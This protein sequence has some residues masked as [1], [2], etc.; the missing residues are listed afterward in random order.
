MNKKFLISGLI[1]TLINL[2]L[3]AAAYI[4]ILKDFYQSHPAVSEEFMKQLHKQPDQLIVWAMVVTSLAMGF[5][6][7][8]VIKWSGA[9]T[10]VSGLK[11]GFV[12]ALLFWGSVNFG[13]YAS[14]NF[15]SQATVFVDYACSVTAMTISGAVAAWML[16]RGKKNY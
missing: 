13:L 4:F 8:T 3:N 14:S 7:T 6:I 2:L 5:L 10:F 1:T 15:F 16:G 12:F 9:K 11:Y